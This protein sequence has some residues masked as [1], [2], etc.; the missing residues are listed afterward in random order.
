ML[1]HGETYLV[2]PRKISPKRTTMTEVRIRALRGR[3]SRGWTLAKNR[4]A[5]RPP[6]LLVIS[7][8]V[9]AATGVDSGL[10]TERMQR[11]CGC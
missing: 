2:D 10:L 3:Q 6:S 7:F 1:N 9:L 5:G 8:M 4:E 11:S